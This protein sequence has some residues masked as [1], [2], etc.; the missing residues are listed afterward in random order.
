MYFPLMDIITPGDIGIFTYD[1][2]LSRREIRIHKC[3]DHTLET[4]FGSG[5][6]AQERLWCFT[7][8][9]STTRF[10]M[11]AEVHGTLATPYESPD[12]SI[13]NTALANIRAGRDVVEN[14]AILLKCLKGEQT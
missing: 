1:Q 8:S 2:I 13:V 11:F 14:R 5:W 9:I 12:P 10:P 4:M 3:F 6:E 7:R